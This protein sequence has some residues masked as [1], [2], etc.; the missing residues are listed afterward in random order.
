VYISCFIIHNVTVHSVLWWKDF[1]EYSI[2]WTLWSIKTPP[3]VILLQFL[4]MLMDFYNIWVNLLHNNSFTGLTYVLLLH[5]LRETSQLHKNN[6]SNQIYTLLLHKILKKYLVYPHSW[7][8]LELKCVQNVLFINSTVHNALQQAS[9]K[10]CL[11]SAMSWY[12]RSCVMHQI[13]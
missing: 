6:F 8:A 12:I 7:S 13:R 3:F 5:Y 11:R 9:V 2:V 4:E 1:I 10:C